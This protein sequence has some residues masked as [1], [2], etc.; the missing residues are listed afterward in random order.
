MASPGAPKGNK[1]AVKGKVIEDAL[2]KALIQ[3]DYKKLNS[4]M[5]EVLNQAEKG[6][7]WALEFIRDTMDGKPAQ[8][9]N[10]DGQLDQSIT[11]EIVKYGTE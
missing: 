3:D 1:N 7:R 9:V 10:L 8:S 5:Q 6:E 2:R 4:G 11:V